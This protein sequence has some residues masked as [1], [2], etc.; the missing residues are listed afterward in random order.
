MKADKFS[1]VKSDGE[2]IKEDV[3]S[4][5]VFKL[6]E[7]FTE[8][9][10]KIY[11]LSNKKY[12]VVIIRILFPIDS[13]YHV[14]RQ[15]ELKYD[16]GSVT[17]FNELLIYD[18]KIIYSLVCS[19]SI[20]MKMGMLNLYVSKHFI[21]LLE[22]PLGLL[23]KKEFFFFAEFMRNKLIHVINNLPKK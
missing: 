1:I 14:G 12:G 17:L 5:V 22:N 16:Q 13:K 9:K 10:A 4:K 3:N 15:I 2:L 23:I 6:V 18:R 19:K 20:N 11:Y 21:A 7:F 8:H